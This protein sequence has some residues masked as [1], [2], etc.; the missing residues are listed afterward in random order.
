MNTRMKLVSAIA[1][2]GLTC[3]SLAEADESNC[4]SE[5][6][7]TNPET[8]QVKPAT[9]V[10]DDY[11]QAVNTTTSSDAE[12][13]A[14]SV[15]YFNYEVHDGKT[16]MSFRI[17]EGGTL[18]FKNKSL[19]KTLRIKSDAK[20]APFDVEGSAEPRWNFDVDPKSDVDVTIDER[21]IA[22]MCFT[23]SSQIDGSDLEDPIVIIEKK[24]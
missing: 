15:R 21:Y 12:I 13:Q 16:K 24:N 14:P 22:G 19:T 8:G 10:G 5:G 18:K 3:S 20:L 2:I 23:Y 6:K 4:S 7:Y 9:E 1:A 17:K 11:K